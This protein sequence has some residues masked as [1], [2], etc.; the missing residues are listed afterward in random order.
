MPGGIHDFTTAEISQQRQISPKKN[1]TA[2][3]SLIRTEC[4]RAACT[5]ACFASEMQ[6]EG[7][8]GSGCACLLLRRHGINEGLGSAHVIRRWRRNRPCCHGRTPAPW[9]GVSRSCRTHR[10]PRVFGQPTQASGLSVHGLGRFDSYCKGRHV[11]NSDCFLQHL[12]RWSLL[13]HT[14]LVPHWPKLLIRQSRAFAAPD[15][16]SQLDHCLFARGCAESST[17]ARLPRSLAS[18]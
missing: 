4:L 16:V 9:Q 5:T 12:R 13:G 14:Q 1:T 3:D 15:G 11:P 2:V 7:C 10:N 17:S 18:P 8:R 6:Q